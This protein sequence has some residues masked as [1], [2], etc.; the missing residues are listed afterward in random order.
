LVAAVRALETSSFAV[1]L[2]E[3]TG[4]PMTRLMAAMPSFANRG[5]ERAVEAAIQKC[6]AVAIDSM[7]DDGQ[8]SVWVPRVIAAAAGRQ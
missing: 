4:Q 1:R 8:A 3:A 6:L 7:D 2:A 5:F